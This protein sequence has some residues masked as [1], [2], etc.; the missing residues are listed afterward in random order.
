MQRS[1]FC[2]LGF[3]RIDH[4]ELHAASLRALE[5]SGGV[6][7]R[8]PA[9]D[10]YEWVRADEHPGVALV[11]YKA[12]CQPLSVGRGG[13]LFA[14]LVDGSAAEAKP[15]AKRIHPGGRDRCC[16]WELVEERSHIHRDRLRA[17]FVDDR[18]QSMCD[19]I[20]GVFGADGLEF[21]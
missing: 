1:L 9:G 2:G 4:D 7:M 11:E 18:L 10:R 6:R 3:S 8:N 13:G 15:E 21:A 17:V 12:A 19:R 5:T 20:H 16:L 14:G